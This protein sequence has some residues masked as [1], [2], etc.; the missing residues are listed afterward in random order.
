MSAATAQKAPQVA[1]VADD[2]EDE[3]DDDAPDAE[4]PNAPKLS[5]N[6][7]KV[8][9]ALQKLGLRTISGVVKVTMKSSNKNFLFGISNP[10]VLK[11]PTSDT[12]VIFGEAKPEDGSSAL[13][14]LGAQQFAQLAGAAGAAG[15]GAA[16]EEDEGPVD[17]EG[18]S[19]DDIETVMTNTKCSRAR[20]VRALKS[21][22]NVV[23]AILEIT[24]SN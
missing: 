6:E 14:S 3:S 24:P 11:S 10:E 2:H 17:E 18:L 13:Q 21:T 9:K 8:R 16:P 4:N 1:D 22:G 7:K 20:A 19:T 12:Y 15:A 5:R 23:D